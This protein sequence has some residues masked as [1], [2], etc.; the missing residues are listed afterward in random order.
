[1]AAMDYFDHATA[2]TYCG[3]EDMWKTILE[4]YVEEGKEYLKKIP[5]AAKAKDYH[6]YQIMA[7]AIKSTSL[8]VGAVAM[9]AEAKEQEFFCKDGK[10]EEVDAG[11]EK[12][13]EDFSQVLDAAKEI[14]A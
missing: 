12:F 7:H 1:M 4:V 13:M 3:D 5:E 11:W 14:L 2:M 6:N 9:N 8:N 10:Y